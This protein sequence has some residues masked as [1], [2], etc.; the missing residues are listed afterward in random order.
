MRR[1]G[2]VMDKEIT[3]PEVFHEMEKRDEEQIIQEMRGQY[4]E[5]FV[6]QFRIGGRTVTG[7]SWAGI[8]EVAYKFG[9]IQVELV[10][11]K[12]TENAYTVIVKAFDEKNNASRLGVSM[13]PKKM[14]LQSGEMVDDEF[15]LQKAV[16]KAQRNAIRPLIPETMLKIYIEKFIEENRRAP[17]PPR[18]VESEQSFVTPVVP[19][20]QKKLTEDIIKYNLHAF[21]VSDN[22]YVVI[23]NEDVFF[24]VPK[25]KLDDAEHYKFDVALSSLGG[26]YEKKGL[27]G[28]WRLQR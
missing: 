24:V 21:G 20:A 8:K 6:Y 2:E 10:E 9:G 23:Q 14:K 27:Y 16:S 11:L 1:R 28:L 12:E 3:S 22:S 7:I 26:K 15:A 4:I 19:Q 25:E 5:E 13:Q 18:R 17:E